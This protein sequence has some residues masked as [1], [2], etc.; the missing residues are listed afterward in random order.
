MLSGIALNIL[1]ESTWSWSRSGNGR[2]SEYGDDEGCHHEA[3]TNEHGEREATSARERLPED[4]WQL[5]ISE[6]SA[7]SAAMLQPKRLR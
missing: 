6:L 3:T 1:R 2:G 7:D 5:N 4:Q